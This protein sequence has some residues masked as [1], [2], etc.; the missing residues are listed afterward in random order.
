[1]SNQTLRLFKSNPTRA[2]QPKWLN[3]HETQWSN[4]SYIATIYKLQRIKVK[5]THTWSNID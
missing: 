5:L 2:K 3:Q 4:Q 1:M